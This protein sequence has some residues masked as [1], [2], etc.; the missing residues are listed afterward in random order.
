MTIAD[1]VLLRVFWQ[2]KNESWLIQPPNI[3]RKPGC[4]DSPPPSRE[5]A[6]DKLIDTESRQSYRYKGPPRLKNVL[7]WYS[8]LPL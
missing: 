6:I 7:A 4:V 3:R 1:R 5:T 8:A 2:V